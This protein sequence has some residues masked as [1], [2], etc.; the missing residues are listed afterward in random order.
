MTTLDALLKTK[1]AAVS[2]ERIQTLVYGF[3]RS[4]LLFTA[5]ELGLFD[6]IGSL[7]QA[8][9]LPT[10]AA[11]G[12]TLT[13]QGRRTDSRALTILLDG[14]IG[15]GLLHTHQG[16][17]HLP[18]DVAC[19]LLRQ[20]PQYLGGLVQHG[21]RLSETWQQLSQVVSSGLP[22]GGAQSLAQ[23]EEHFA[24]LVQGLYVSNTNSA[25]RLAKVLGITAASGG[26]PQ[27]LHI[28]DIGGGSGVWSIALLEA[29]ATNRATVVDLPSVTQVTR[30]TYARHGLSE[31]LTILPGDMEVMPLPEEA[32]DMVLLANVC[33]TQGEPLVK[34]LINKCARALKPQGRLVIVDFIPDNERAHAGWPLLFAVNLL[35]SSEE[36]QVYTQ[37]QYKTWC[38]A[39]NLVMIGQDRLEGDTQ[40]LVA[41]KWADWAI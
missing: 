26:V 32:F 9:T 5:L 7:Q 28:L 38:E 22:A 30:D 33:H 41:Q 12:S 19:Y 37:A 27:N 34:A 2:S 16:G 10:A 20:S 1:G 15:I 8:A 14:L 11:I 21:K 36:G 24:D 4:Q 31:R 23:I 3:A 13:Q 35:V 39:A 29:D 25:V 18:P 6:A 40:A 17:Y